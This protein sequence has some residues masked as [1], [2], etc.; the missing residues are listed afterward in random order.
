[1]T[2]EYSQF[3][4]AQARQETLR[5]YDSR[6]ASLP[7][8]VQSRTVATRFGVT[9]LLESGPASG[10][11]VVLLHGMG[12]SAASWWRQLPALSQRHRVYAIDVV[13]ASGKSAGTRP[14]P[15]TGYAHWLVDVL[16]ALQLRRAAFVAHSLGGWMTLQL[17]GSPQGAERIERAVLISSSGLARVSVLALWKIGAAALLAGGGLARSEVFVR[18]ISA[19]GWTPDPDVVAMFHGALSGLSALAVPVPAIAYSRR[20]LARLRAPV[21]VMVG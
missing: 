8:E 4:S 3:R 11:P 13:G 19:P 14:P 10:S 18:Q 17:A 15:L 12:L 21:W 9:H 5:W 20:H 1:M 16:D 6:V 7:C 2:P